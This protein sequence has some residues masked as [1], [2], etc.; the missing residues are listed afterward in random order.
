MLTCV[1]CHPPADVE[2]PYVMRRTGGGYLPTPTAEEGPGGLDEAAEAAAMARS[3]LG[4]WVPKS[5]ISLMQ[6]GRWWGS[7]GVVQA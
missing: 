3:K 1:C 6:V 5:A 7:R 4:M 2:S